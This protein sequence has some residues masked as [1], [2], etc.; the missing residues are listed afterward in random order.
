MPEIR[1][2]KQGTGQKGDWS[3]VLDAAEE[4]MQKADAEAVMRAVRMQKE[5]G[6]LEIR[7]D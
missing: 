4:L 5:L 7:I 6:R 2:Y 1:N 3:A